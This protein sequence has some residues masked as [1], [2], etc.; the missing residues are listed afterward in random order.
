M[1]LCPNYVPIDMATIFKRGDYY[2][3]NYS[4]STG[5]HK[6]PLGKITKKGAQ[7]ALERKEYEL[8]HIPT[9]LGNPQINFK[10][11]VSI[12][13]ESFIL[14]F[15]STY[16]TQQ[17]TLLI[18]FEPSFKDLMLDEITSIHIKDFIAFKK[19]TIAIATINRKLSILRAMLNQAKEDNYKVP[20]IKITELPNQESRPPKYYSIKELELIYKEDQ[21]YA[22]WWRFLANT[23][24]RMGEFRN[25]R[26]D[27]IHK[28]AIYI[29]STVGNRTK[30]GKWRYIPIN[31]ATRESLAK[32]DV[33]NEF[34]MPR[35][36]NDTPI[37]R[38]RRICERAG[39]KREKWGVHCLR[40]TFASHLVMS[41][42]PLR[43]VQVLLGHASIQTTERY[44]HLSEDYL[45]G[46]L[47]N[48]NL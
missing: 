37:T 27:D 7:A 28:E 30:S 25:L 46:S 32:F 2:Y 45:K 9:V 35:Q 44:A 31:K 11:Y 26:V 21:L 13:L 43:T 29:V 4:D 22:H 23:G 33:T 6:D 14:K 16:E 38:F 40:H 47:G 34:L 8:R 12:Y 42:T 10:D 18:D 17:H 36:H 1:Q 20:S 15:P 19:K 5:R 24:L 48:L 3:L 41:G 39:I